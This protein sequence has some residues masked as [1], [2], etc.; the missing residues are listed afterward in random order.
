MQ[1]LT[2]HHPISDQE[3]AELVEQRK[4]SFYRVAFG[5]MRNQEE[6]LEVVQ[7]AVYKAY[8]GKGRLRDRSKFYPWFYRIL[9]NTAFP[10]LRHHRGGELSLEEWEE[11]RG[12][13]MDPGEDWNRR[14]ALQEALEQLD[15][16]SR[17]VLILKF[18]E[19]MTFREIAQ[20]LRKPE[21][22]VKTAYYRGL[23]SLKER[24]GRHDA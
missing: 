6:A 18:Y 23:Q 2:S 10:A 3:F 13:A 20:V 17:N 19:D 8:L 4:A 24:M 5:Y 9:M 14:L 21:S 15:A 16:K 11:T 22:T 7:E 1:L 12:L